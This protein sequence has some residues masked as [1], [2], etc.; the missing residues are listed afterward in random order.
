MCP[1]TILAGSSSFEALRSPDGATGIAH[2]LYSDESLRYDFG[3]YLLDT[4]SPRGDGAIPL[5]DYA[6]GWTWRPGVDTLT[7]GLGPDP[8]PT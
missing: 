1:R 7:I 5:A 6:D 2:P 8:D 4:P 3:L